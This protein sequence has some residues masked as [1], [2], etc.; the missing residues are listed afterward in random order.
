MSESTPY[1]L[2][3]G[4][5]VGATLMLILSMLVDLGCDSEFLILSWATWGLWALGESFESYESNHPF[6]QLNTVRARR[7]VIGLAYD[8]FGHRLVRW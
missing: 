4:I 7:S 2:A 8:A 1:R 5:C 3:L 6:G